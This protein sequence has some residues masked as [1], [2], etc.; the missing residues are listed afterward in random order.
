MSDY[1]AIAAVT[2]TLDRL[3][4]A[5]ANAAVQQA[6]VRI[7]PPLAKLA[8]DG[9]PLVNIFLFRVLPNAALRNAHLPT[10]LGDGSSRQRSE[11]AIDLHYVFSFYGDADTF[12][13]ERLLGAVVLALEDAPALM[14]AAIA[15]AIAD[16]QAAL[17]DADLARAESRIRILPDVLSLED[18]AKLWSVFFQVPYALSVAYVCS[19]VVLETREPL[20]DALPVAQGALSVWPMSDLALDR[21]GPEPGRSGPIVRGGP[22]HLTGKGLGRIGTSVRIDATVI[23]PD[24]EAL[25]GTAIA[26]T[27]TDALFGGTPLA[28]GGHVVQVLA[29]PAAGTPP[30]L[31][32]GSN[33]LP[34]ALHPA[35]GPPVVAITS[36]GAPM[37]SGSLTLDFAPPV[38]AGQ[39]VSV[40]LDA[41][42]PAHPHSVVLNPQPLPPASFPAG[43]MVFPFSDLPRDAYL[44]RAEVD[45]FASLVV[46]EPDPLSPVFGQIT[47]PL[48]DLT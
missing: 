22:L 25:G 36:G 40:T 6:E 4:Q 44:V 27:L 33:A 21:V 9:K 10:R 11:A 18:F 16:N 31:R 8:E 5:A 2:A 30:H 29:P 45:G 26:L 7:G 3:L 38:R 1:R 20:A 17:G 12:E 13:P 34:F 39:S 47:G 14:P 19:H 46:I 24:P 35:I 32:R 48:A 41:R 42:D 37:R 23:D 15:A 43:Q 28:A